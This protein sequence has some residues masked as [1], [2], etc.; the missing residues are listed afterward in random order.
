MSQAPD[1]FLQV[2]RRRVDDLGSAVVVRDSMDASPIGESQQDEWP[3]QV[4]VVICYI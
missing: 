2:A 4:L 3:R 1:S